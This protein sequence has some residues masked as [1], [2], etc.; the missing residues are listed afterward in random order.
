MGEPRYINLVD[1]TCRVA[2]NEGKAYRVP[3]VTPNKGKLPR[4]FVPFNISRLLILEI[5]CDSDCARLRAASFTACG[6]TDHRNFGLRPPLALGSVGEQGWAAISEGIAAGG[7]RETINAKPHAASLAGL[8]SR[9]RDRY[10]KFNNP[11]SHPERHTSNQ[12][13]TFDFLELMAAKTDGT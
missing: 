8:L 9:R 7:T 10:F 5:N 4:R 3:C 6:D 11:A 2:P 1:I 13:I 12:C